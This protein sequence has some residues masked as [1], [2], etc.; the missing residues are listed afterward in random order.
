[1]LLAAIVPLVWGLAGLTA[2]V[3]L[4]RVPAPPRAEPPSDAAL[5]RAA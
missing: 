3:L 1:M 4:G 5:R 2:V